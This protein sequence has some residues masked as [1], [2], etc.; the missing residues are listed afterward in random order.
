MP[1]FT[2]F[3]LVSVMALSF[4]SVTGAQS[5][6]Q[7]E[8][9]AEAKRQVS[10]MQAN[11]ETEALKIVLSHRGML[12]SQIRSGRVNLRAIAEEHKAHHDGTR[13]CADAN[14][15]RLKLSSSEV[16][17]VIKSE[18]PKPKKARKTRPT[19]KNGPPPVLLSFD[20]SSS[21]VPA[22]QRPI[23]AK[24]GLVG[25]LQGFP[26]QYVMVMEISYKFPN[27]NWV[28]CGSFDPR[29]YAPTPESVGRKRFCDVSAEEPDGDFKAGFKK[30]ERLDL[31]LGNVG[32]VE[33]PGASMI[34]SS[35][36]RMTRDGRIAIGKSGGFM[37][38]DSGSG[39]G[40]GRRSIPLQ[41]TYELD[42]HLLKV[43]NDDGEV[44]VGFI[45]R[46]AGA[47][48]GKLE[49]VYVNGEHFWNRDD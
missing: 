9:G 45:T 17:A 15:G 1:Q 24:A 44:F 36:L 22:S 26:A 43:T 7:K 20:P 27:G 10:A 30:G 41:G 25:Q 42:G 8:A 11:D 47:K 23:A 16:P 21:H 2:K 33:F 4:V 32:G 46:G 38:K 18:P 19:A 29:E 6:S 12:E 48:S 28:S 39:V 5:L 31:S 3:L 37:A 49:H 14:A 34:S 13:L 35:S 40:G